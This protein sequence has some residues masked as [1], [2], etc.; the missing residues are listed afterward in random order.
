MAA[1]TQAYKEEQIG[2]VV[3][4]ARERLPRGKSE[5][6][7]RFIR[8]YYANVPD[9]VLAAE[10]D[11]LYGAAMAFYGFARARAPGA[12]KIRAYNPRFEDHG[13]KSNHTVIEIVND[14][15]PFLVDSVTAEINR[16]ELTVHLVVHPILRVK[17]DG[18]GALAGLW[19]PAEAAEGSSSESWMH[20]EIDEES[21]HATLEGLCQGLERVLG[22]VRAAVEDWPKMRGRLSD[23]LA[24]LDQA[25]LPLP[26]AELAEAKAF[27]GWVAGEH[28]TFLGSREYDFSG[29]G[30]AAR[31]EVTPKTGLGI[32]RDD[33]ELVFSGRRDMSALP[34]DVQAFL[35]QPMLLTVNKSDRRST[36]HRPTHLDV[37]TVKKFRDDGE[38][39]G[40]RLFVGLF[41]SAAYNRIPRDIPLMRRKVAN[42]MTRSGFSPASHDG[43][44]LLHILESY[45]RDD[46]FQIEEDELFEIAMG[47]LYLQ[48]RQ[49]IALFMRKDPFERFVSCLTYVPRERYNTELRQRFGAILE[50]AF[51]G[52]VSEFAPELNTESALARVHFI[53][54]T[55]P[56]AIP[57]A[58]V[59]EIELKL[60]EAAR[61]WADK[62]KAALVE[63]KGEERGLRLLRRYAAAFPTDYRERFGAHAAL[64]DIDK[65]ESVLAGDGVGMHLYR[66]LEMLESVVRFKIYTTRAAVA[67]SDILPMLEGMGLR[68]LQEVPFVI[69][70]HEVDP[71]YLH[72]FGLARADGVAIELEALRES[73]QDAFARVLAGGMEADG[74]NRLVLAGGL[75]WREV[76]ILRAYCKYLRQT[77]IAFSQAYMEETLTRNPGLARRIVAL[78]LAYFD[79]ARQA[80]AAERAVALAKEI[81]AGL[82]QVESLDEDRIIRR[83]VNLVQASLRTNYFQKGKDG[84]PKPY[85]SVKL[86]SRKLEELPEPHPLFEIWV[87]SPRMEGIHLRGGRVARGGIRWSDRREDFRTEILGLMKTQ[88]V[89]NTVIVPVGSKGGFVVKRPPAEGGREA[90]MTEVVECYRTLMRGMLDLTDNIKQGKFIP[91]KDVVRRDE[92]DAY[93]VVAADKG[94]A[95][96]SDIANAVSRDEY[97]FWLDD[98]FASGGSAG[99]DHKKMG[100]T[101]KGAWESVKRH[102]REAGRDIQSEDFTVVGIGDMSGDVFGNGMLLSEHIKLIGAFNHLHIFVD[103]A[104]DP[105]ASLAERRRLFDLPR[106]SWSDYDARLISQGG[107]VFERRAKSIRLS[108]EMKR[109]F[110][111]AKDAA[112]PA[113]LIHAMLKAPVDLLWFGGIGTYIK[114]REESQGEAGDRANDALRVDADEIRAK[115]IG[116]GANL[117]VTQRG[118]VAFAL[119][120]GRINTDAIDNS[121][122]VATSDHEVN[123]KILLGDV[124]SR[125]DM[126]MKQR[127]QLLRS[128]E[129]EVGAHVLED[130]YQQPQALTVAEAEGPALLD[131]QMLLIRNLERA[132]RLNRAIE[133]LPEDKALNARAAGGKGLTRPE[134]AAIMA[135]AKLELYDLLLPSGLPDDPTLVEDLV[136]YFPRPL[137]EGYRAAIER[138]SLRREIIATTVTNSIVNRGGATFV[139]TLMEKCGVAA[140][141]A[142]RA[143]TISRQAFGLATLWRGIEAL[144]NK[145]EA[146]VQTAMMVELRRALERV[147]RWFLTH[148]RHPLDVNGFVGDYAPGI[149]RLWARF[150]EILA[151]EDRE[152]FDGKV[153]ALTEKGVP[154]ELARPVA[155]LDFLVSGC[156]IVRAAQG[157]A[158]SVEEVGRIY[159]AIGARF[160][161]DWLRGAAE[162]L[163]VDGHWQKLAVA[164]I[165]DDLYAHQSDLVTSVLAGAAAAKVPAKTPEKSPERSP[166]K[167]DDGVVA[168]WAQAHRTVV[169]RVEGVLAEIKGAGQPDLAML[170]VANRQLRQMMAG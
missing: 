129:D 7:E 165:I 44:A 160:G 137:R 87:Y 169:E 60:V 96:F 122:G 136:R 80:G 65:I 8:Q 102:F 118:R 139:N 121:A 147:A 70:P 21:A 161:F 145:V 26:A 85:L 66:P 24:R 53:V 29:E 23:L 81:E 131:D 74:F 125:G 4:L 159:F 113:E 71:V 104:P 49:R 117:G 50:A 115:V 106:S 91:P 15:M 73:F 27:L 130:N 166:E 103:P 3:G 109:L 143:Y 84:G 89:K 124:V 83:F 39:A 120:G 35:R 63:A 97:G 55:T 79:P 133:F 33:A 119:A 126:T 12:P 94:T 170:A 150:D 42:V 82:D 157:G 6:A 17:R 110:A 9:D 152:L 76:V 22:D 75:V 31:M 93:L 37:V 61:S 30:E 38:V 18:K 98:A 68:V 107:G 34:P 135:Y 77:G 47:I 25:K 101:A 132:G 52:T 45:P 19:A 105:K 128:I 163:A 59:E 156:D 28:F 108:P 153:V 138:H 154:L 141:D 144:D 36:V 41:T 11:Q 90:L 140:A 16:R 14:D 5:W 64:V 1:R 149:A 123:L 86:D 112:T 99:Y 100:I 48:E 58:R 151:P 162:G 57:D 46:L 127:D 32:L 78:F 51:N 13:W 92:D 40:E 168:A 56:G 167:T 43:K 142:A 111:L 69:E 134:L 114:A 88:M 54:A 164:A 95:T 62:L 155:G 146:A 67:L 10:L 2:R 20:L 148:G 116:E 158:T 72:D